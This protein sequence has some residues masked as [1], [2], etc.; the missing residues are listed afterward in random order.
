MYN[1]YVEKYFPYNTAREG[2]IDTIN[3][4]LIGL[5]DYDYVLLDAPTGMG[6]TSVARTI[7]EYY[8]NF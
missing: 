6:K 3:E 5:D 7:A 8:N 2:Q 4:S 1:E